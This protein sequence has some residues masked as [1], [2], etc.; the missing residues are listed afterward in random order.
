MPHPPKEKARTTSRKRP[1]SEEQDIANERIFTACH[2]LCGNLDRQLCDGDGA[3]LEV[4]RGRLVITL[5]DDDNEED[6]IE[7]VHHGGIW[8]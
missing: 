4:R 6:E 8:Q 3:P 5:L 2:T 7:H 1:A